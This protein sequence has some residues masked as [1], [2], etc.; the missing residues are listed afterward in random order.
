MPIRAS[1]NGIMT[2][3]ACITKIKTAPTTGL[4]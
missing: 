3:S 1:T 2:F 4:S